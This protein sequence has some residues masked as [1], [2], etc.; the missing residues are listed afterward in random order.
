MLAFSIPKKAI[1]QDATAFSTSRHRL[2]EILQLCSVI[3]V[4]ACLATAEMPSN[5][6]LVGAHLDTRA[7]IAILLDGLHSSQRQ[8]KK[9]FANLF[10]SLPAAKL[11]TDNDTLPK[12]WW[13]SVHG[14]Q[15]G[16]SVGM[17]VHPIFML[18]RQTIFFGE[19]R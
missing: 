14:L 18:A 7:V 2:D 12:F 8:L 16:S 5:R 6:I 3:H 4:T 19:G 13:L 1:I 15:N 10:N 11:S 9:R 17:I